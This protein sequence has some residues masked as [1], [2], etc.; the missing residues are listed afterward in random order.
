MPIDL[1]RSTSLAFLGD[2][3]LTRD[4]GAARKQGA[5]GNGVEVVSVGLAGV[6]VVDWRRKTFGASLASGSPRAGSGRP[7]PLSAAIPSEQL[8]G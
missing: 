7:N 2:V 5:P 6:T 3:N 1:P 4:D 8:I